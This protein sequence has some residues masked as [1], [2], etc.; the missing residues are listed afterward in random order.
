MRATRAPKRFPK[1][2]VA[3]EVKLTSET[4]SSFMEAKLSSATRMIDEITYNHERRMAMVDGN[5]PDFV[6]AEGRPSIPGPTAVP[7]IK[8][9]A[10]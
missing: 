3:R 5:G 7:T 9:T 6:V 10:A 1:A 8:L 2:F 4:P